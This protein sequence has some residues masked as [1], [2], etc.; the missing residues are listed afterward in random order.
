MKRRWHNL[1]KS[2]LRA[3]LPLLRRLPPCTATRWI[4]YLGSAEYSLSPGYRNL[5]RTAV[6]REATSRN[7]RWDVPEVGRALAANQMRSWA[8]DLLIEGRDASTLHELFRVIGR[9]HLEAA[10]GANRGVVLLANHY[11]A[12]LLAACWLIREGFPWRMFGERP[13]NVSRMLSTHFSQVGPLGQDK[14]FI[15]RRT[16]PAEAAS[17]ILRAARVLKAGMV[18]SIAADVRWSGPL[19]AEA[20]FLGQ[21]HRFSSTWVNLAAMTGAPVLPNF[22]RITPEGVYEIEFLPPFSIPADAKQPGEAGRWVQHALDLIENRVIDDPT[23]SND[24]FFWAREEAE[25]D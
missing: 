19:T 3:S 23:N 11:G 9:E 2:I 25:A 4:G 8:R 24:Y 18:L 5:I 1:R 7:L 16:N 15:S 22:C 20:T 12:H 14:L 10:H 17:S 13:R 21:T 6:T